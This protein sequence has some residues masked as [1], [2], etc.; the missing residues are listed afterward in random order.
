M[1]KEFPNEEITELWNQNYDISK[2]AY[3]NG[4]WFMTFINSYQ[5]TI[6]MHDRFKELYGARKFGDAALFFKEH[7]YRSFESPEPIILDY[8]RCFKRLKRYE[9]GIEAFEH[10]NTLFNT[11]YEALHIG[12]DLYYLAF[13]Q[14]GSEA[15]IRKAL[16]CYALISP[17]TPDIQKK[18]NELRS[19]LQDGK[20]DDTAWKRNLAR[21]EQEKRK[22]DKEIKNKK[23]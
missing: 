7:L 17:A 23:F 14:K 4:H 3:G 22:A 18:L 11:Y 1:G 13:K 6:N 15:Y 12:A 2:A 20:G 5:D 8:L 21:K 9:D 16:K 10:Y 19:L